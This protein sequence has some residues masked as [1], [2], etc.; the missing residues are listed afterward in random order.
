MKA[1]DARNLSPAELSVLR[2]KA[3]KAVLNDRS[4][5]EMADLLGVSRQTIGLWV[6]DYQRRG[7]AS[8]VYQKRGRPCGGRLTKKQ[9]CQIVKLVIDQMPEQLKLPFALWSRAAVAALIEKR[10]GIKYSLATVGRYLR[11]WGM[12]PQKP[13]RRAW[14]QNPVEV[15]KWLT[16]RYPQ[17]KAEAKASGAMV[18]WG[19]EMGIRSDDQVGRS[20]GMKGST[21]VVPVSGNRF[22]CNMISAISNEGHMYFKVFAERF[23]TQVFLDFLKRLARECGR[24]IRLIVDGHPVH[25]SKA[26]KKWL[27]AQ[28]GKMQL[29][30]LPGYSPELNPDE[31]VNQDVK[32]NAVRRKR[33]HNK[34][35]LLSNVRS[36]LRSRQ[37]KPELVQ[38]YFQGKHVRYAS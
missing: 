1:K 21:P 11:K 25:R 8:L 9:V 26:V 14:E 13:V 18:L 12:T 34:K 22:G 31:M 17:V 30:Q 6:S 4:R 29:V 33:P 16:T 2:E 28:N 35:E 7:D 27:A 23:T 19:D 10:Y 15:N 5:V 37:G 20:Y 38:R 3:V 36:Y 32:G 24:P